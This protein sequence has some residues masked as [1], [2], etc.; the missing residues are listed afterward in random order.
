MFFCN[1]MHVERA[2]VWPQDACRILAPICI[3]HLHIGVAAEGGAISEA[4]AWCSRLRCTGALH[5]I[6]FRTGRCWV[7]A[8]VVG[9][10]CDKCC[11]CPHSFLQNLPC[12]MC[13]L[14]CTGLALA[15]SPRSLGP[16]PVTASS[17]LLALGFG[18]GLA[19]GRDALVL[20][21]FWLLLLEVLDAQWLGELGLRFAG[22]PTFDFNQNCSTTELL[23]Q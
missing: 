16:V 4:W 7:S 20:W 6:A 21:Y 13:L 22:I 12:H 5:G 23:N 8:L 1:L 2:W 18:R 19:F 14:P 3:W 11:C 15:T 9:G 10:C 17:R